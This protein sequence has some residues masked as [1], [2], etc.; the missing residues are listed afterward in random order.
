M[1]FREVTE[2]VMKSD[3][4]SDMLEPG[5]D[6][7]CVDKKH[8]ARYAQL[9]ALTLLTSKAFRERVL[10]ARLKRK[11]S[12]TRGACGHPQL[13]EGREPERAGAVLLHLARAGRGG[14]D[15]EGARGEIREGVAES[16]ESYTQIN[17]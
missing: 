10:Q 14:A 2:F 6:I 15:P 13:R 9:S 1:V 8:A 11:R 7:S 3:N 4:L 5:A 17:K 16:H 12:V